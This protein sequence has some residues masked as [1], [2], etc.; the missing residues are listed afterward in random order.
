MKRYWKAYAAVLTP[1]F[2]AIQAA[3]TDGEV[4]NAELVTIA[5]AIVGVILVIAF[6]KNQE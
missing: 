5:G 3:I 2:V 4:T 1:V 6:P